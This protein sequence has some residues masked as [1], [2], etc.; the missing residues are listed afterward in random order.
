MYRLENEDETERSVPGVVEWATTHVI[1][2]LSPSLTAA[3]LTSADIFVYYDLQLL[4]VHT[5]ALK[6]RQSNDSECLGSV[7]MEL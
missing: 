7:R 2:R 3:E 4:Y 1:S 5:R 6:A